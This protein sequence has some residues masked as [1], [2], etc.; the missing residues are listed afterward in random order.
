MKVGDL[1]KILRSGLLG[2][3]VDFDGD[4]DPMVNTFGWWGFAAGP[5]PEFRHAVEVVSES[6]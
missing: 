1:V 4:G 3:V 6:R 5:D 2:I